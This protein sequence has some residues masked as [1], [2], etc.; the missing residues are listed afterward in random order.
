MDGLSVKVQ[1]DVSRCHEGGD[2]L[3]SSVTKSFKRQELQTVA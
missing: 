1:L 3:Y 2:T